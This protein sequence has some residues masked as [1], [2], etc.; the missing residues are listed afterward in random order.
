MRICLVS[1]APLD[2][3]HGNAATATRW[4][5][6]LDELGH[7][8][9]PMGVYDGQDY[10]ALI[11]LHARKSAHSLAT[12]H[13]DRPGAP[14]VVALTG[15]DLYP[16]LDAA[17]VDTDLLSRATRLVV[18]Q[19]RASDQ[20]PPPLRE[21]TRVIVQSVPAIPARTPDPDCFEI[22]F[23]SHLRSV[24]DPMRLAAATRLLP[25]TSRIRVTHVGEARDADW[26]EAARSE[27]GSNHRYR[28]LGPRARPAALKVLA[29]SRLL[30]LTS[31]HEGGAN[32][33]SEAL[34][35]GVPVVCSDIPGSAGLLGARYPGYFT[36][37]DTAGLAS[38]LDEL[39]HDR[40][41][42]YTDLVRRCHDMRSLVDPL[43]ERQAWADLLSEL[44]PRRRRPRRRTGRHR[45]Q[46]PEAPRPGPA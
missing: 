20:L 35:A 36:A 45:D 24:K 42:R 2:G 12:F 7:E 39:E 15:T 29:R 21:R 10:D 8:V 37:G 31:W 9:R 32:V 28:W 23:L 14:T 33:I 6:I 19:A 17:G 4:A 41:G 25:R 1:P 22:A 40:G 26:A 44:P 5:A 13:A 16:S 46:N 18:L 34:A 38:L 11:A 3:L 30:A 27:S 43:R